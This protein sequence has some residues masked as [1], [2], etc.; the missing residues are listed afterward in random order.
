MFEHAPDSATKSR[1]VTSMKIPS[2]SYQ[3]M[4]LE[5][6]KLMSKGYTRDQAVVIV[7]NRTAAVIQTTNQVRS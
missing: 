2:Y 7:H 4:S 3:S 5:V 6:E 1:D